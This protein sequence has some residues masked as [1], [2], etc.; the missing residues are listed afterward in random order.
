VVS[1]TPL[2]EDIA[3]ALVDAADNVLA[4]LSRAEANVD[5]ERHERATALVHARRGLQD[6]SA[7][8]LRERSLTRKAMRS[9]L[10]EWADKPVLH[11]VSCPIHERWLSGRGE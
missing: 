3:V 11:A 10:T 9:S 8:F 7:A 4:P 2:D 6:A 5:G 1:V